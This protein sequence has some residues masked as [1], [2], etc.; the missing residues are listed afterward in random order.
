MNPTLYTA[1]VVAAALLIAS[2]G[3]TVMFVTSTSLRWG[4][5][6]GLL[7]VAGSTLAAGIQLLV[8]VSG[9]ASIAALAGTWFERLRWIGVAYLAYLGLAAWLGSKNPPRNAPRRALGSVRA[10]SQ[11][12]LITLTNPKTLLFHSAFLPQ[13]VDRSS[14]ELPQ[15]TV[16]AITF[17]VVAGVGDGAW[18]LLAAKVGRAFESP[19]AK[20][21][22]DRVSGS[23]LLAAAA[24]L[25][26]IRRAS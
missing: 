4:T 17:L 20:R 16:L 25:A 2:P 23:I 24:A 22:I 11:G 15:M 14:P 7:A 3:P 18:A 1:F 26:T 5:H 21:V 6:A 9:L 8:V 12:F 13:F 19:S 10:F